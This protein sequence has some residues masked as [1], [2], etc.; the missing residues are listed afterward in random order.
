MF[1]YIHE[2]TAT[3]IQTII[4]ND[5]W[6]VNGQS[7]T[8]AETNSYDAAEPNQLQIE[9]G[10]NTSGVDA[11]ADINFNEKV[12]TVLDVGGGKYDV[13][14]VYLKKKNMDLFVWDPYNRSLEHNKTVQ[15]MVDKNKVDAVTSM[16][17][18]NV[19]PEAN[20]RLAHI[21]TVKNAL[22]LNGDAYF[23]IWQGEGSLKASFIPSIVNNTYQENASALR[24]L[25][26]IELVF[27]V[28]NVKLDNKIPNLIIAT[29]KSEKTTSIAEIIYLQ[30]KSKKDSSI[31]K[32]YKERFFHRENFYLLF[33]NLTLFKTIEQNRLF[34]S[35]NQTQD[36]QKE[37][38]KKYGLVIPSG[39]IM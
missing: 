38:D 7:I 18:L 3:E 19:I 17:V 12:K 32:C 8:S 35:K 28:G 11:F 4:E 10:E 2:L 22:K 5:I 37:F 39:K 14:Q 24:F 25:R 34:Q 21:S 36:H 16:S 33:S 6:K 15:E 26:D 23:K 13:N 29:K 9:L 1:L 27:G 30:K 20:V 31:Y